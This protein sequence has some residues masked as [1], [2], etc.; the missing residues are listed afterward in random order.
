MVPEKWGCKVRTL[1]VRTN[2]FTFPILVRRKP[3]RTLPAAG[4]AQPIQQVQGCQ[5][6]VVQ[7]HARAGIAHDAADVL[8]LFRRVAVHGALVA[9]GLPCAKVAARHPLGGVFR[10]CLARRT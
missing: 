8:T 2:N 9:G 5:D 1:F 4:L 7:E 6:R 3:L 10:Q